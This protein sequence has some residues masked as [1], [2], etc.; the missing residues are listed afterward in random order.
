VKSFSITVILNVLINMRSY[1][2]YNMVSSFLGIT[3]NYECK[4]SDIISGISI[5]LVIVGGIFGFIQWRKNIKIKK[6]SYINELTEKIRSDLNIKNTV[7]MID[8]EKE[9][10][11]KEFHDSGSKELNMDKTLSYF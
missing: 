7:Y 11:N 3:F 2:M 10:Y 4:V 5:L 6:A 9:W 8:Y 1:L